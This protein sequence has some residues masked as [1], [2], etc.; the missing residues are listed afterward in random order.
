MA[1]KR[2][3]TCTNCASENIVKNGKRPNGQ[4]KYHCKN[5]GVYRTIEPKVKY[6][7]EKRQ[8]IIK[9]YQERASMRGIKRIYGTAR[10]TLSGWLKKTS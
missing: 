9:V 4:Q 8:E 2:N 3:Y 6:T 5:C 10:E 1:I 7:E